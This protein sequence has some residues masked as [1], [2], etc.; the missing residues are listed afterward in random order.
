[1]SRLTKKLTFISFSVGAGRWWKEGVGG[2]EVCWCQLIST[3]RS[4]IDKRPEKVKM[5]FQGAAD[6]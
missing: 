1:M 4:F 3:G 6:G 5:A 2:R